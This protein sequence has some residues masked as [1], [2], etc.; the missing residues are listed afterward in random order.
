MAGRMNGHL[1]PIAMG[2]VAIAIPN[3]LVSGQRAIIEK[4]TSL[5]NHAVA[6]GRCASNHLIDRV[7]NLCD[8]LG[9]LR[10]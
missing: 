4:V 9:I 6:N 2:L 10:R 8:V 3:M 1:A 7:E 5:S